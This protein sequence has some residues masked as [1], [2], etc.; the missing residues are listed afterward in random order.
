MS[1]ARRV[2][3]AE[4]ALACEELAAGD[5]LFCYT[6]GLIERRDRDFGE[7]LAQLLAAAAGCQRESADNAV[8]A[9]FDRL[10]APA[11]DDDVCVVAVRVTSEASPR[12]GG[13]TGR[14]TSPGR[15]GRERRRC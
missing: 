12:T 11:A 4:Y 1:A 6:N 8:I 2:P 5:I 3:G 7:G 9:L 15:A 13:G 10:E 14:G